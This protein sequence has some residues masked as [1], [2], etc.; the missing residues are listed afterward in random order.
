MFRAWAGEEIYPAHGPVTDATQPQNVP[1]APH[2]ADKIGN[3]VI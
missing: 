3:L 1:S 2:G